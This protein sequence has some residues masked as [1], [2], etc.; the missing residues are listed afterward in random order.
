MFSTR[1]HSVNNC[2]NTFLIILA[3]YT[4][5]FHP[6]AF[7]QS[8]SSSAPEEK[9]NEE[10]TPAQENGENEEAQTSEEEQEEGEGEGEGEEESEEEGGESVEEGEIVE[11]EGEE[12]GADPYE[13]LNEA[14]GEDWLTIASSLAAGFLAASISRNCTKKTLDSSTV[15]AA[16][17][18]YLGAEIIS[19]H[20]DKETREKIEEEHIEDANLEA[21]SSENELEEG[22]S[23][24]STD[25]NT[26]SEESEEPKEPEEAKEDEDNQIRS[27]KD[28]E[29]SYDELQKTAG[30]KKGF[31]YAAAGLLAAASG[32]A[33]YQW[34]KGM[35]QNRICNSNVKKAILELP[36]TCSAVAAD[37]SCPQAATTCETAL[38]AFT[39]ELAAFNETKNSTDVNS[40]T[41]MVELEAFTAKSKAY[42]LECE[43]HPA[44]GQ[45]I[46][47][48]SLSCLAYFTTL[49][50]NLML[51]PGP[52]EEKKEDKKEGS[53]DKEGTD[54]VQESDTT[55]ESTP[56]V[57][58]TPAPGTDSTVKSKMKPKNI[59]NAKTL[60][61]D[62]SFKKMIKKVFFK[63]INF[64]VAKANAFI[65]G[66]FNGLMGNMGVVG[67]GGG[68]ALSMM[69]PLR[70]K[71]DKWVAYPRQRAALWTVMAGVVTAAAIVSG[72]IEEELKEN[73]EYTAQVV[74]QYRNRSKDDGETNPFAQPSTASETQNISNESIVGGPINLGSEED[75]G[76]P[77]LTQENENGQCAQLESISPDQQTEL[78]SIDPGLANVAQAGQELGNGLNNKKVVSSA[79]LQKSNELSGKHAFAVKRS[80]QLRN[81]AFK[82]L[83]K[84]KKHGPVAIR[85]FNGLNRGVNQFF[86]KSAANAFKQNSVP[87]G[88]LIA[89]YG[90]ST[91]ASKKEKENSG[92]DTPKSQAK[93]KSSAI[94]SLWGNKLNFGDKSSLGKLT[95][96]DD[97][98]KKKRG[99]KNKK[100]KKSKKKKVEIDQKKVLEHGGIDR[101]TN[102]DIFKT[103][104]LRYK[105]TLYP[106]VFGK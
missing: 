9:V 49:H 41:K 16:G 56:E 30:Q 32:I 102:N 1:R 71:F 4:L 59:P 73:A 78:K 27:L 84:D 67:A 36:I 15:M 90:A 89:S 8:E 62:N 23:N 33:I 7:A 92:K 26:E 96:S 93:P 66:D 3:S 57:E 52:K 64:L 24:A 82:E 12:E 21:N 39:T 106:I 40:A 43:T 22:E 20:K 2:L 98:G 74:Q 104:N 70:D 37:A 76:I 105:K 10:Q 50:S 13:S 17:V 42:F 11:G 5:I 79:T 68:V 34:T 47:K 61:K 103:I 29:E 87:Q 69:K 25:E 6:M 35:V 94:S 83:R 101:N 14:E 91:S 53:T 65:G 58:S 85:S 45:A 55:P 54:S 38:S 77:C 88:P 48:A 100:R 31:Q 81:I 46:K 80:K 19:T 18:A 86:R 72:N 95:F 63:G 51:C 97:D 28:Q 99:K 44:I 75:D 60:A